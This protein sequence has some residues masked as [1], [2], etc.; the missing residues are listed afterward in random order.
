MGEGSKPRRLFDQMV[1]GKAD[2]RIAWVILGVAMIL[3]AAFCLWTA[4]GTTFTGD[5]FAWVS[6]TPDQSLR[7]T[8]EP[9]SGHLVF[10][11]LWLYKA[12]LSTIGSDYLTFRLMTIGAVYLAV[13]LLFIFVRKRVGDFLALAP[14][15]VLL[16]FGNDTGNII[17]GIGF[18]LMFAVALGLFA[19]IMIERDTRPSDILACAALVLAVLTFSLALP[20]LVG[21]VV[22]ILITRERWRRIWVVAIPI[23]IYLAWRVWLLAADVEV[24]NGAVHISNVLL[25]P[26][27]VFQSLSGVL[28]ALTGFNYDFEDGD[29]LPATSLAGPPLA[30]AFIVLIGWRIRKGGLSPWFWVALAIAL[31]L[32]A[33]QTLGWIPAVRTPGV[34]R[35]LY[36]GAF[37][38]ILVLAETFRGFRVSPTA[39]VCVWLI[40]FCALSTNIAFLRDGGET[41]R[42]RA[43]VVSSEVTASALVTSAYPFPPGQ[44]FK[45]IQELVSD[46][47]VS[48][49]A[50]AQEK[51]GGIGYTEDQLVMSAP[52]LRVHVDSILDQAYGLGLTPSDKATCLDR[53]VATSDPNTGTAVTDLPP[54]GAVLTSPIAGEVRLKRFGDDFSISAG[55]LPAGNAMRLYIPVDDGKTP[56][57]LRVVTPALRVCEV[58]V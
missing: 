33:S 8:F 6:F 54:G 56:W 31:S 12:V 30:L 35:Y 51:Y 17:Q 53:S 44:D 7:Y 40:A 13:L 41:L 5:E 27:W 10:V 47:G 19:L 2:P 29:F 45:P 52:D 25:F 42:A 57:Q 26:S 48:V 43:P 18:T 4:R 22:A 46:P 16:L 21:A 9:Q 39:F 58:A 3:S 23:L 49:S 11:T 14:C 15:L 34:A 24:F 37:V 38:L 36:P 32:F 28:S 50:A 20:F 1:N 55:T